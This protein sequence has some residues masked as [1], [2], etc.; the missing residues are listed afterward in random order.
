MTGAAVGV[1]AHAVTVRVV[2]EGET[3]T[4]RV[5]LLQ[6]GLSRASV[7]ALVADVVV[8]LL[9]HRCIGGWE[10]CKRTDGHV[11]MGC[12]G[13]GKLGLFKWR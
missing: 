3:T 5:V 9:H 11:L 10:G 1:V 12:V 6:V 8:L 13:Y 7:E 2:T 4:R